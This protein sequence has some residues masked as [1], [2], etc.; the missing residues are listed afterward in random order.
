V[1]KYEEFFAETPKKD[2][3]RDSNCGD[4]ASGRT[5]KMGLS[6]YNALK[7]ILRLPIDYFWWC[8][9]YCGFAAEVMKPIPVLICVGIIAEPVIFLFGCLM[10]PFTVPLAFRWFLYGCLWL[11]FIIPSVALAWRDYKP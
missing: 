5:R 4:S 1:K 9:E 2:S 7:H 10:L 6:I 8:V 3:V 11:H